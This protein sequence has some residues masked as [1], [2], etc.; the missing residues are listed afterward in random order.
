MCPCFPCNWK[1]I[2]SRVSILF[3]AYGNRVLEILGAFIVHQKL[4]LFRHISKS[5]EN[6]CHISQT[7]NFNSFPSLFLYFFG[8]LTTSERYYCVI[9]RKREEGQQQG[10]RNFIKEAQQNLK[11]LLERLLLNL[12]FYV[13]DNAG[14]IFPEIISSHGVIWN[15]MI[16]D[17]ELYGKQGTQKQT[18]FT[19]KLSFTLTRKAIL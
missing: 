13:L 16:C 18:F 12:A 14:C 7:T 8:F 10:W 11:S 15:S 4:F 1:W 9:V 3:S 17:K 6:I 5:P 2:L 19:K